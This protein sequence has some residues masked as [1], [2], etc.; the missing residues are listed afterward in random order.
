MLYSRKVDNKKCFL[1]TKKLALAQKC[2][3]SM[4]FNAVFIA[5]GVLRLAAIRLFDARNILC[6]KLCGVGK[7][8]ALLLLAHAIR[9]HESGS[10]PYHGIPDSLWVVVEVVLSL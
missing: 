10:A 7:V 5:V 3:A 2:L 8:F 1:A 9:R 4:L 6:P